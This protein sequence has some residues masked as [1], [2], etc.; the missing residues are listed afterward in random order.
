MI[1]AR[2]ADIEDADFQSVS[3]DIYVSDWVLPAM[4]D[5][6]IST[7]TEKL[8]EEE[9]TQS[10]MSHSREDAPPLSGD[11]AVVKDVKAFEID[12]GIWDLSSLATTNCKTSKAVYA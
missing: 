8:N 5:V 3:L 10:A 1:D 12:E 9:Q 6:G 2:L 4:V 11:S 7:T